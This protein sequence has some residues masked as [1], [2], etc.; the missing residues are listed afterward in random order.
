M[1][2]KKGQ[3]GRPK[4]ALSKVT[5][6]QRAIFDLAITP[7][8]RVDMVKVAFRRAMSSED[9]AP[10]YMKMLFDFVFSRPRQGHDVSVLDLNEVL[11]TE[12]CEA[13]WIEIIKEARERD[14]Q[15][16]TPC[17]SII[18]AEIVETTKDNGRQKGNGQARNGRKKKA[19][20]RSKKNG[21]A[22][23]G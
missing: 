17:L 13:S 9:N 15:S 10:G 14:A 8:D 19:N 22:R 12:V 1:A 4:G 7:E 23:K 16:K 2:F 6:D 11:S 20:S 18:D 21:K 5:M 3:G